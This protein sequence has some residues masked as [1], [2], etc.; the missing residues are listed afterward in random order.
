MANYDLQGKIKFDNNIALSV[1]SEDPLSFLP[2][3]GI[4]N[5]LSIVT[6][7]DNRWLHD[8]PLNIKTHAL[9]K[10]TLKKDTDAI[11][12]LRSKKFAEHVKDAPKT[13]Y[14]LYAPLDPPYR[15]NP[16]YLIMN[17]PTIAHAYENKRYF[18]DEFSDLIRI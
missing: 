10:R 16:L 8:L 2:L 7:Y 6:D 17:S 15:V 11:T 1:V 18:R 3:E 14:L 13:R 12:I 9:T 4:I 5:N